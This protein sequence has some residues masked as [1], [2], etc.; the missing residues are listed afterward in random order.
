MAAT[1]RGPVFV[2]DAGR[3]ALAASVVSFV[4][5]I[6]HS[7]EDFLEGVP[8]RFGLSM[9]AAAWLLGIA[10]AIQIG[11]L[12]VAAHGHNR[13]ALAGVAVYGIGW[14]LAALADHP[15]AVLPGTFRQ[16][17]SSRAWVLFI[18]VGQAVAAVAAVIAVRRRH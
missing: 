18:I 17:F 5:I 9:S 10:V 2:S 8:A 15:Q 14:V 4:G 12:V 3:V 6:A 11:L 16:G 13:A 7:M 1:K